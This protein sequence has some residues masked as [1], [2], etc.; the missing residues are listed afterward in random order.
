MLPEQQHTTCAMLPGL[1]T[2]SATH[3]LMSSGSVRVEFAN[4]GFEYSPFTLQRQRVT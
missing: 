3:S 4:F 1:Q 2:I